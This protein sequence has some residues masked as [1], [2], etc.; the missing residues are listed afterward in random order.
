M[1][2][3]VIL[4][5]GTNFNREHNIVLA[6]KKLAKILNRIQYTEELIT[7]PIGEMNCEEKFINFLARGWTDNGVDQIVSSFKQ[8]ETECGN[9][10]CLRSENKIAMDIDLLKY[11][12][13]YFH[14][15][16]WKR[17]YIVELMKQF[18]E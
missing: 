15:S 3:R 13:Q 16:D 5:I 14:E 18:G 17:N 1:H 11:D 6:K 10:K 7:E 9:T 4:S 2:H 12:E 8:V